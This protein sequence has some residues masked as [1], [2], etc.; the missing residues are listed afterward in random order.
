MIIICNLVSNE[1][2]YYVTS[3]FF[4]VDENEDLEDI[5]DVNF[6]S[7]SNDHETD[8]VPNIDHFLDDEE[9]PSNHRAQVRFFQIQ[10]FPK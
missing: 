6:V 9:E 2:R 10:F 7:S 1:I 4:K 5:D 8:D 3:N